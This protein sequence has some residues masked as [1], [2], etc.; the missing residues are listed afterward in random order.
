MTTDLIML[1]WSAT[2]CVALLATSLPATPGVAAA[3]NQAV[4][5]TSSNWIG[6]ARRAHVALAANLIPFAF[7]VLTVAALGKNNLMSALGAET[8]FWSWVAHA[9]LKLAGLGRLAIVP[10]TFS[11]VG[12]GL[13][14]S[15]L[16]QG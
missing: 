1:A 8:F 13:V 4:V 16:F 3:G 10:W 2:L 7:V 5:P 15:A 14:V 12:T 9:A 6:R 11:L